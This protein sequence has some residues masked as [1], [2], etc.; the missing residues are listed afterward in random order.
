[1]TEA[2]R[3][4]VSDG[5]TSLYAVDFELGYLERTH[6]FVYPTLEPTNYLV[7]T[8]ISDTQIQLATSSIPANGIEFKIER[9]TPSASLINDFADGAILREEELDRSFKQAIMLNRETLDD[10]E[11]DTVSEEEV[12]ELIEENTISEEEVLGLISEAD[13]G[14]GG[15]SII[16][17]TP[18]AAALQGTR[19]TNCTNQRSY[20]FTGTEWVEDRPSIGTTKNP[21]TYS[22]VAT[23]LA[24]QDISAGD[25]VSTIVNNTTSNAGGAEYLV[26]TT[27][28]AAT[29]GDAI[30]GY[31]NHQLQSGLVAILLADSSINVLAAGVVSG[32]DS[33]LPI[34]AALNFSTASGIGEVVIPA[35]DWY[36]NWQIPVSGLTVVGQGLSITRCF[37]MINAPVFSIAPAGDT[38]VANVQQNGNAIKRITIKGNP[39]FTGRTEEHGIAIITP[40]HG[41]TNDSSIVSIN[42]VVIEDC[43]VRELGGRGITVQA[44]PWGDTNLHRIVQS[45]QLRN[46]VSQFNA[47]SGLFI[48]GHV[49]ETQFIGFRCE[50]NGSITSGRDDVSVAEKENSNL[51]IKAIETSATPTS[52]NNYIFPGRIDLSGLVLAEVAKG[53]HEGL[54]CYITGGREIVLN[55][56]DIENAYRAIEIDRYVAGGDTSDT[57]TVWSVEVA[58]ANVQGGG[59]T[60]LESFATLKACR[61]FSYGNIHIYNDGAATV[62]INVVPSSYFHVG[63]VEDKGGNSLGQGTPVVDAR[64]QTLGTQQLTIYEDGQYFVLAGAQW[65]IAG[66]NYNLPSFTPSQDTVITLFNRSNSAPIIMRE[67]T[68][69]TASPAIN[70]A[71]GLQLNSQSD[72]I[73][74]AYNSLTDAWNEIG[75]SIT[76][77][78]VTT[79]TTVTTPT[80]THEIKDGTAVAVTAKVACSQN[81]ANNR[82]YYELRGLAYRS[83]GNAV[84]EGTQ[85]VVEIE[86]VA[87]LNASIIVTG[88]QVRVNVVGLAGTNITWYVEV[89]FTTAQV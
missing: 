49:I 1:M 47:R 82:A 6:V 16:S 3:T 88:N 28:Q 12:L 2:I 13:L 67:P 14:A 42:N 80:W 72:S 11:E 8:W 56:V 85:T 76:P 36:G 5:T 18:P 73:T 50:N 81:N 38:G 37:A 22:T 31:V 59:G 66:L 19:W 24:A 53:T 40:N 9:R 89:E 21:L 25:R 20:V 27:A 34:Q 4:H 35:G 64:A 74:L 87:G 78:S 65:E 45:L 48:E 61:K 29:D 57:Q 15:G 52:I 41:T 7:Y 77:V 26:K 83:G 17:D 23:M 55:T 54:S 75:R 68:V 60:I 39:N 58:N 32:T 43:D 46:T 69:K 44:Q 51:V 63:R 62:G 79:S 33:T 10:I 71:S 70:L 86:S 84:L 30:D